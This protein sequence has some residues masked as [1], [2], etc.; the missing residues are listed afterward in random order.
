MITID[1]LV[2]VPELGMSYLA[3]AAGGSR[4]ITWAHTCDQAEPWL[5]VSAGDLMMTTGG[6]LPA[7]PDEQAIWVGRIAA[8]HA[9]GLMIGPRTGT[10]PVSEPMRARADELRF[11]VID[12]DFELEFANV[13]HIVI[14][15]ALRTERARIVAVRRLYDAW[16]QALDGGADLAERLRVV[17]VALGCGLAVR[18]ERSGRALA[19][20]RGPRTGTPSVVVPIPG[21]S[22][23]ELCAWSA[24]GVIDEVPLRNLAT[25][26]GVDLAA[27]AAVRSERRS[28]GARLLTEL[29]DDRLPLTVLRSELARRNL[30]V[31]LVLARFTTGRAGHALETDRLHHAAALGD[32]SPLLLVRD[33]QLIAVLPARPELTEQVRGE[34]ANDAVAGVS[35]PFDL[36][37]DLPEA[38]RQA[39]LALE[40]AIGGAAMA[41]NYGALS[42]PLPRTIAEAKQLVD[43]YLGPVLD[44]DRSQGTELVATLRVFLDNDRAWQATAAQL[45]IHRQTL[46]YRLRTVRELTGLHPSSTE[47]TAMFWLALRA[48]ASA[49]LLDSRR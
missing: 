44:H 5:W 26:I 43:R 23:A 3:G 13:A 7:D 36:T 45:D 49:G 39:A 27:R 4:P 41:V 29:L 2:A 16:A 28:D 18:D 6:G 32:H 38:D 24:G 20:T 47:A 21:T 25:L 10:P 46:A 12:A 9:C 35:E 33:E 19:T 14:E 40:H 37:G 34:L 11:P 48:G 17:S 15:S 8:T 42:G 22:P 30:P 31:P 1:E